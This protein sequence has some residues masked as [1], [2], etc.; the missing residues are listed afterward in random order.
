MGATAMQSA[1]AQCRVLWTA[2]SL[3]CIAET[4]LCSP[5]VPCIMPV[6]YSYLLKLADSSFNFQLR[7]PSSWTCGMPRPGRKQHTGYLAEPI[8]K[9]FL[10]PC[11]PF[12]YLH[13]F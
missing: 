9:L 13:A 1:T 11:M 10:G 3:L 4:V 5:A 2:K 12:V 8:L 6:H 7:L